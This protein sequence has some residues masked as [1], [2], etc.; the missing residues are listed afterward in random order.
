L[1]TQGITERLRLKI[2]REIET[3]KKLI[4]EN[5]QKAKELLDH[6]QSQSGKII[7]N[8]QHRAKEI[9]GEAY[10]ARQNAQ[11]YAETEQALRNIIQG[12]GN[13]Y[14]KPTHDLLDDLAEEF[15][16]KEAGQEL[17]KCRERTK[18][19]AKTPE[20]V[21]TCDYVERSRKDTAINFVLDAFMGKVDAVLTRVKHDNYGKLEQEIKDAY[22]VVN[23]HGK[24]FRNA[25]I[26][27][28]F[29]NQRLEELTWA[30]QVHLLR[31]QEREEQ[32]RI[33]E[34]IR[35]EERARREYEK[36]QRE[37][38]KE[39]KLLQDAMRKAQE[40]LEQ[41]NQE[42]RD[43]Y[44]AELEAL[45]GKLKEAEEKNQ[46]ALS[47]AQQTKRGHVYIISN[48]GSFGEDVFKIGLTRRLEPM[49]R[50]KELGDASVPFQFDVHAM[51]FDEDAPK[52]EAMLHQEFK[53]AQVNKVNPRKEFF[54]VPISSIREKLDHM[55]IE[56]KW[57]M[58]AEAKE[59]FESLSIEQKERLEIQKVNMN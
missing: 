2:L 29:L 53:L 39:E 35:E 24:A 41:A 44:M 16:Y 36:A 4:R 59:Y 57:T 27:R 21:A 25:R 52:L 6:A 55:G 17:K 34:A 31:I 54:K 46:R 28:E 22:S 12:Y 15:G 14:L 19:M 7:D 40:Q 33:K 23:Y 38:A 43:K 51:I 58:A 32:K 10:D 1:H 49:D 11:L 13:E 48:I 50:V 26:K 30:V 37:A 18:I 5:R 45:K 56:A 8:A 20:S 3:S 47:M 9:A 42:E